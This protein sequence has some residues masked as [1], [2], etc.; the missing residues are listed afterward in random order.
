M[1]V[2]AIHGCCRW[3]GCAE[4]GDDGIERVT[5]QHL[6]DLLEVPQRS[7]GSAACRRLRKL[8][9]ELGACAKPRDRPASK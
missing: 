3:G 4:I 7:R 2:P 6:F 8:M 9:A 1:P 5:T